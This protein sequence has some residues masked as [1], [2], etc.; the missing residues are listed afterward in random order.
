MGM[1]AGFAS[2]R[3]GGPFAQQSATETACVGGLRAPVQTDEIDPRKPQA[4]VAPLKLVQVRTRCAQSVPGFVP[5]RPRR[6][7]CPGLWGDCRS[8]MKALTAERFVGVT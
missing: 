6:G 7:H 1:T 3:P 8:V 2:P 5:D 4:R